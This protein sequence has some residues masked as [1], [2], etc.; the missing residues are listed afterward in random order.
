MSLDPRRLMVLRAVDRYGGVVG[1]ADVLRVSPSAISQQLAALERATGVALIDRSRRG[2]QRPVELTAAG[3][4][5][6]GHAAQLGHVLDDAEADMAAFAGAAVGPVTVAAFFS[7]LSGYVGPALTRL[8]QTHPGITVRVVELDEPEALPE[9]HAGKVDLVFVED[10]AQ[11][12]RRPP[13]SLRYEALL[14]DPFRLA[15]PVDWPDVAD[16]AD[17]AGSPWVDG[18]PGSAV[19]QALTRLRRTTGMEF[20][21]AHWCTEF[22]TALAVVAAGLAGAFVPELAL[23]VTSP[24]SGVRILTPPGIGS[25]RLGV[26]YRRSR[27][28]PTPAVR[29][30]LEDLHSVIAGR[31]A[32]S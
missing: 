5:L 23:A 32:A 11:H 16:L 31:A 9:L 6:A 29:A 8:A 17:I 15:V 24:Q 2:G 3:R 18:P 7:I 22:T 12:R 21:A 13:A 14:D 20:P 10:D 1:A 25:R 28:E 30:A 4:R 27:H 26:L 19:G